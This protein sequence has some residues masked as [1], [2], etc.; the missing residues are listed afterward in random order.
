VGYSHEPIQGR[1]TQYGVKGEVDLCDVEEDAL[2]VVVLKCLNVTGREML[3]RGIM[4]PGLTPVNGRESWSFDIRI[5]S[6]LKAAR[7]M[8][9]SAAPPLTRASYNL[10]LAM[11]GETSSGSSPAPAMFLGQ[12]E[13]SKLIGVSIHLW[14]G[15]ALGVDAAAA[16]ARRRV[17]T[18]RRYMM[19]QEP[20]IHDVERLATLI[21]VGLR[22]REVIDGLQLPLAILQLHLFILVLLRIHFLLA[23]LLA[24]RCTILVR[25]LLLLTE[26]FHE[27]PDLLAFSS[28][29]AH[30][31]IHQAS[32][33]TIVV[34]GRLTGALV[35]VRASTPTSCYRSSSGSGSTSK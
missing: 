21:K 17:L 26:L 27:V 13:A 19:S 1:P 20:P 11:V 15:A 35:I 8:R 9:L 25:L 31:V 6:F 16:T 33:I 10:M 5:C 22:V 18:A 23:L 2:C 29:V 24:G 28:A 7:L 34:V 14:W 12:T 3:P 4:D 32:R 30:E